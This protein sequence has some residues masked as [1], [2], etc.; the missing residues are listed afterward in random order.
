MTLSRKP[1]SFKRKSLSK[2]F[3]GGVNK[4]TATTG[5]PTTGPATKNDPKAAGKT[6][7]GSDPK[8]A[9]KTTAGSDPKAAGKNDPKAAGTDPAKP[10]TVKDAAST[11]GKTA[12]VKAGGKP[13]GKTAAVK[14]AAKAG[15]TE[16]EGF[17]STVKNAKRS[18]SFSIGQKVKLIKDMDV[19]KIKNIKTAIGEIENFVGQQKNLIMVRWKEEDLIDTKETLLQYTRDELKP[20]YSTPRASV[21]NEGTI[22]PP[23]GGGGTANIRPISTPTVTSNIDLST[24]YEAI[25][26]I[27][28]GCKKTMSELQDTELTTEEQ[29]DLIKQLAKQLII[30]ASLIN[31]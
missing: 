9:G 19:P 1:F 14:A 3:F 17:F 20:L 6:T 29:H 11:D 12:A 25:K 8:A 7:A 28:Q 26:E 22:P 10:G 4:T 21:S 27:T 13:D 30:L 18:Q 5:P 24:S 31:K 2:K 16:P 15:G 23:A